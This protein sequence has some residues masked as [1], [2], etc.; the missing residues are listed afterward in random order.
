MPKII[1][2]LPHN[3]EDFIA[4][5]YETFD[6]HSVRFI[7]KVAEYWSQKFPSTI[8][9]QE[10]WV[11]SKKLPEIRQVKHARGFVV[12]L[13]PISLRLPLPLEISFSLLRAVKQF[14]QKERVIWHL[15]SYYLF[16][17]DLLG[18]ILKTKS[19]KFVAHFHGGGPSWTIK[20][21]LYTLYHYGIGLRMTLHFAES[22]LVL[23]HDEENRLQRWL[24]I[25]REKLIYFP[26]PISEK[27]LRSPDS[28]PLH[29]GKLKLITAGRIE[30]IF[31][32]PNLTD[33]VIRKIFA[34]D[35][36]VSLK[37][38]G[39]RGDNNLLVNLRK[40]FGDRIAVLPWT[41][42]SELLAHFAAADLYLH[43]NA[44]ENFEGLPITLVEAQ[45]QGLPALAVDIS[46]VRDVI[47]DS[48]NGYLVK[49]LTDFPDKI[50]SLI[51]DPPKIREAG[52]HAIE[53]VKNTFLEENYFNRL[54]DMYQRI[55]NT[56]S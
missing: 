13:F 32:Q 52:A 23:N 15:H 12:K 17:N 21:T 22:I 27:I 54:I 10:L 50:E 5:D 33:R 16:M 29:S 56:Q 55:F 1:H 39:L 28:L 44:K 45:S 24:G 42:Q 20:S 11:I 9:E 48:Y 47:R 35:K 6:H 37:I 34:I 14:S 2:I 26:N 51:E 49:R 36:E 43:F 53:M 46:G 19:Q 38:V 4:T 25:R 41:T 3:I 7:S 8:L 40:D 30:K 18:I 31:A